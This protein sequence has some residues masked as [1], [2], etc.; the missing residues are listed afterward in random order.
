MQKIK[1]L[2]IS[3]SN[4][5]EN[6]YMANYKGWISKARS[7]LLLDETTIERKVVLDA[8]HRADKILSFVEKKIILE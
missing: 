4:M 1:P 6:V 2:S 7:D 8:I 5:T 3:K